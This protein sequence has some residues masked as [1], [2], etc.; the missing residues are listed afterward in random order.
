MSDLIEIVIEDIKR[1][2]V[3]D[4]LTKLTEGAGGA[5]KIW[6][7]DEDFALDSSIGASIQDLSNFIDQADDAV[8]YFSFESL[9]LGEV[10]L[11]QVLL[12]LVKYSEKFDIDFSFD[13]ASVS[14]W[15]MSMLM[16]KVQ[17]FIAMLVSGANVGDWFGG[18]EPASDEDTRY[19]TQDASGPLL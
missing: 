10:R 18:I 9:T 3:L 15:Q 4:V 16:V 14:D 11:Q 6:S 17:K 1:S 12:R 13:E 2:Q 8:L 7:S 19:F 5:Q